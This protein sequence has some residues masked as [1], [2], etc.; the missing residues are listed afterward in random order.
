MY[1]ENTIIMEIAVLKPNTKK[2]Y[3]MQLTSVQ[4]WVPRWFFNHSDTSWKSTQIIFSCEI[5]IS[6][7]PKFCHLGNTW[8]NEWSYLNLCKTLHL[9]KIATI[10]LSYPKYQ[11]KEEIKVHF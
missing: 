8:K 11:N 4:N 1:D 10:T 7:M 3:F 9:M 5:K 2:V 6:N